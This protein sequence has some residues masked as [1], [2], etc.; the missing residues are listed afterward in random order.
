M[1]TVN[2]EDEG[3]YINFFLSELSKRFPYVKFFPWVAAKLFS[4]S[5]RNPSLRQS[6]L[7][8][9]ALIAENHSERGH[10]QALEYLQKALQMLQSQ[11][12]TFE[13][14]EGVAISSFLLAHFSMMLGE[15]LTARKHLDGMVI[16][17]KKLY[18]EDIQESLMSSLTINPLTTLIWRMAKRIDCISS[19]ACGK[20]PVIPRF[21]SRNEHA[22]I[23][24][25]QKEEQIRQWIQFYTDAHVSPGNADWAEAWFALDNLMHR[26]CHISAIVKVLRQAPSS[27]VAESQVREWID[28]L[29]NRHR[30]WRELAIVRKADDAEKIE[31]FQ[32]VYLDSSNISSSSK[33]LPEAHCSDSSFFLNYPLMHISDYFLAS[34]LDNW[35]AIQLYI[36]LIQQPM[37]GIHE[38]SRF[39]CAVDL[40]RTQAALGVERNYLEAEKACGLYLA[41]VTFGG[42]DLYEVQ[43]STE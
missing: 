20:A 16:V 4:T 21:L 39:M 17:L 25:P 36:G 29:V 40:C 5:S 1:L 2:L 41:G 19:I 9:A 26:T 43:I 13:I 7:S 14:D 8:V 18:P 24:L 28:Y 31:R 27:P 33:S 42:P 12:S 23:S 34:R 22:D 6:V 15:H 37:W 35:R 32:R 11:I 10:P 30:E 38:D 3:M